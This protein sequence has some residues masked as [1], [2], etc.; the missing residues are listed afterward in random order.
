MKERKPQLMYKGITLKDLVQ[1]KKQMGYFK[2]PNQSDKELAYL[3][4][5]EGYYE[6]KRGI[7]FIE[8]KPL[9]EHAAKNIQY[10]RHQIKVKNKKIEELEEKIINQEL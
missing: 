1:M 2:D 6:D 3:L 5:K 7:Y 8:R 4:I 10:L 9:N